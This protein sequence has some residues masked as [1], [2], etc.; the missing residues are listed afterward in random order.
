MSKI[1]IDRAAMQQALEALEAM[2][3]GCTDHDDG[4]VEAITVWCPEI[5]TALKAALAEPVQEPVAWLSTDC[6]GERYLGFSKPS[7][8]DPVQP[9]YA[10][11]LSASCWSITP[12]H[13]EGEK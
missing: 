4:T 6:I 12:P 7:D 5:I 10:A 2:Q 1:L 3:G 8:N 11:P 9:L 13:P